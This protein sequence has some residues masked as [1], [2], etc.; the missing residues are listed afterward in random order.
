MAK[1][2]DS[3]NAKIF[4]AL[5]VA[6][7]AKDACPLFLIG[8]P[9]TGKTA[10]VNM[11]AK[12]R[13]YEVVIVRGNSESYDSILGYPTTPDNM[14]EGNLATIR[15]RPDWFQSILDNEAQGKK[16]LLFLDEITTAPDLVQAALLHLVIER[17]VGREKLPDS[18]LIVSAGNYASNLSNSMIMLA[19]LMNRFCIYNVVPK[20]KDLD[21]FLCRYEG[22][23]AG[24][25]VDYVNETLQKLM[26]DIDAQEKSYSPEI[27]DK[28]GEY[29][30][31]R[32]KLVTKQLGETSKKE[33][34]PKVTELGNLYS[35]LEND[36][37]LPGIITYRSLNYLVEI[38]KAFYVCF[39]KAGIT[40]DVYQEMVYGLVGLSLS[41]ETSGERKGELKKSYVTKE[42]VDQMVDVVNDIEKMSNSKLPEYEAFFAECI[43][44][45]KSF[46]VPTMNAMI[47]KINELA[48]D[49][50]MANI[51]RPID[52]SMVQ[53]IGDRLVK[54]SDKFVKYKVDTNPN[55]D[56]FSCSITPEQ[57]AG[58]VAHWNIISSLMTEY[59]K[60][61][62]EPS[63]GYDEDTKTYLRDT[64][65]K[66][67][68]AAFKLKT[69]QK[70]LTKTHP[71][72][73]EATV[74]IKSFTNS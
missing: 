16:S 15:L 32:V 20:L 7:K 71:D 3:L 6:E 58:D 5:K 49:R 42:Y 34:D 60:L 43:A 27:L 66:L 52:P 25:R 31:R 11:F 12:V 48:G 22:S 57:F 61:I 1:L 44:K 41:R 70:I 50:E 51:A 4:A 9:G 40:S 53:Q 37:P 65:T 36:E 21:T 45:G 10:T 56:S 35:D 19:P 29:I 69:I 73:A 33:F 17:M 14:S 59:S 39:G 2:G 54:S 30:E 13:G 18:T 24:K 28:I 68:R 64:A 46:D 47:N 74:Q 72:L 63:R 67:R 62:N 23:I 38:T 8:N 55:S 26:K